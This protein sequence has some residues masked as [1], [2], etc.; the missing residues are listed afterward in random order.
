MKE[1]KTEMSTDCDF[2][3]AKILKNLAALYPM[4]PS[5]GST[6]RMREIIY[7]VNRRDD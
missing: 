5:A 3:V 4:A 6:P 7:D 1:I 2:I